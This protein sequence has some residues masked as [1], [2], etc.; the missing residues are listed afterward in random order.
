MLSLAT[1]YVLQI[2]GALTLA[3]MCYRLTSWFL[4]YL[5]PKIPLT[6]YKSA[7]E[8][9]ALVTGASAGI[10]LGFAQE[11]ALRGFNV[12]LLGHNH[13][14]LQLARASLIKEFPR[15]K[16]ELILLDVTTATT[17]D[18]EAALESCNHHLTVL[19]NNVGGLAAPPPLH[20]RRLDKTSA[21]DMDR[22]LSLNT[23]FM[24]HVTRHLI[25]MLAKNGPSLIVNVGSASMLGMPGVAT[26]SG[27]KGFVASFTKAIAREMEADGVPVDVLGLV[28]GEVY[29]QGNTGNLPPGSPDGRDVARSTL[30]RAVRA[31]SCGKRVFHP[32]M[33]HAMDDA[34]FEMM[35]D[36]M[37]EKM[38]KTVFLNKRTQQR[39]G[40]LE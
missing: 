22:V 23:T 8:S 38:L 7:P 18:I 26:Y 36:W 15:T 20:Y 3:S 14:E 1:Q 13:N 34:I 2:V 30:G 29:T 32:W 11:L 27:C 12:I 25:P 24:A 5:L 6:R 35:P 21:R 40:K 19:I 17:E 4:F 33:L 16:V 9:W 37:R 39:H 31:V 10:G 28:L